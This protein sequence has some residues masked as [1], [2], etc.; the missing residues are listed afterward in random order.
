[1]E[2]LAL[3]TAEIARKVV[4]VALDKQASNILLL[5][6]RGVCSFTDY[7]VIC[8]G[9]SERQLKAIRD[10]ID[11]MLV[12]EQVSP[13]RHQGSASSGWLILDLTDIVVHLFS[14]QQREFYA[15]EEVWNMG[16]TVLRI[17]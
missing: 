8:D 16:S 3:E 10:E 17:L 2:V 5:D 13:C 4:D 14:P 11:D 15:L 9:E 6:L 7:F 1:V 12:R